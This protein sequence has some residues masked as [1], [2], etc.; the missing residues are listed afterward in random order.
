MVIAII[1][2]STAFGQ[3]G[4]N[5]DNSTPDPSAMLDVKSTTKGMLVPRMTIAERTLISNPATGLLVFCT[6]NNLFY[7]NSGTP[8]TP[9]WVMMASQWVTT[10]NDIFYNAGNVG[11]GCLG[12]NQKLQ[13]A[14]KIC[15]EFGTSA[16]PAYV[17]G[18]GLENTG[19]SSPAL[20]TITVITNGAERVRVDGGGNIGI[21]KTAPAYRL[22]VTG[23]I[24]TSAYFR[25]NG[26][27]FTASQWTSAGSNI[28]FNTGNI[29]I[30]EANPVYPL[31]FGYATG[32]KISLHGAGTN[33]YGLG[34][35]AYQMQIYTDA[36]N[37]D[38]TFGYGNSAA[39]TENARIKGTGQVGIGTT[40][41]A[42][43][44][45]LEV[46]AVNRGIL[47][48][49]MTSTQMLAIP[50]PPEG[51]TVYNTSINSLCWFNGTSWDMGANRDGQSCAGNYFFYGGQKYTSVI[52]GMQCWLRENLNIGIAVVG[53]QTNNNIVEKYCYGNLESNCT[54]YGGLYQWGEMMN[55]TASSN[56]NPS[57]RQGICP[58]GWHVPSDAEWC[59]MKKYIDA[60]VD[61]GSTDLSGTDA[62]A[63]MKEKGQVHWNN[64]IGT[65]SSGFTALGAGFRQPGGTFQY[66]LMD[67]HFWSS[68]E[69]SSANAWEQF[70]YTEKLTVGRSSTDKASGFSVRC[71]RD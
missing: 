9:N 40:A 43:A 28:Y 26:V 54:E 61:C 33:H 51:L 13:V 2:A 31:N 3:V 45:A 30:G 21:G 50:S 35:Q 47:P 34:I 58:P 52:I 53:G 20:N 62:G 36:S 69:S 64:P 56:A 10:G 27:P 32:D 37:S 15:A 39:F 60:T 71:V 41:P 17:F 49:R 55:Y 48:P 67:A 70:L 44:A 1:S 46:S 38:I 6:D 42:S 4:I 22:D 25:Q 65:N 12:A 11:I 5:S 8:A 19:F 16:S 68:T 14:G 7:M 66:Q 18:Y 23:D 24:N 57:G 29:G 63:K 59:Q